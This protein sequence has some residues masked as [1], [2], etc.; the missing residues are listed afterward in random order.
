MYVEP[1]G[2]YFFASLGAASDCQTRHIFLREWL[3]LK[4]LNGLLT[5]EQIIFV[6]KTAAE[7]DSPQQVF[8]PKYVHMKF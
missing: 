5:L 1:E 7:A 6:S 2:S 3:P 4:N 8:S